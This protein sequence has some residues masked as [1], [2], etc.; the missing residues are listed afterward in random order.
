MRESIDEVWV[1]RKA[2]KQD[3]EYQVGVSADGKVVGYRP[4]NAPARQLRGD[5]RL[6]LRKI[7]FNPVAAEATESQPSEPLAVF[8]VVLTDEGVPRVRPLRGFQGEPVTLPVQAPEG[9]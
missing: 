8:K 3:L 4:V 7:L 2:V 1:D 9:E 5:R 6:P